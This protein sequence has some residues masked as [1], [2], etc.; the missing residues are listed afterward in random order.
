MN[1]EQCVRIHFVHVY[2]LS[3]SPIRVSKHRFRPFLVSPKLSFREPALMCELAKRPREALA[4]QLHRFVGLGHKS[5]LDIKVC[6]HP[7]S[8][9]LSF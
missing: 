8:P 4:H 3:P 5:E 2:S 9:L 6:W 1:S 7:L